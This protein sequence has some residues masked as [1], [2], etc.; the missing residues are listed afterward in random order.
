MD[1]TMSTT[2]TR[3][4]GFGL[5]EIL[6]TLAVL[7]LGIGA[8]A[9]LHGVISR[10]AQ[11]N[12]ARIEAS[13]MAASRLDEMRNYTGQALDQA[14]F[15]LLYPD[16]AGFA[17]HV[18]SQGLNTVFTRSE[19]VTTAGGRKQISVQV[20]WISAKGKAERLSVSSEL[21]FVSPHSSA[22]AAFN[23]ARQANAPQAAAAFKSIAS[24]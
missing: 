22:A 15:E 20:A 6:V 5:V 9:S 13:G 18:T 23:A 14:A 11:D 2:S 1:T 17:N 16:T 24:P 12:Q 8:V 7:A 4:T 3:S 10:Q 19:R 21:A